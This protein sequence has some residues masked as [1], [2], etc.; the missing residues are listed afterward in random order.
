[1]KDHDLQQMYNYNFMNYVDRATQSEKDISKEELVEGKARLEKIVQ[2]YQPSMICFV[3]KKCC[4]FSLYIPRT[5]NEVEFGLQERQIHGVPVF[6]VPSGSTK[7]PQ[8]TFSDKLVY[9]KSLAD[10]VKK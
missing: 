4:K 10:L 5:K 7:G 9:Y 1:M 6:C 8:W 3:G 2:E